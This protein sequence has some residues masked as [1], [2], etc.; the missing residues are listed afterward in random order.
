MT[1]MK[2]DQSYSPVLLVLVVILALMTANWLFGGIIPLLVAL[3]IWAITG[4]IAGYIVR[5]AGYNVMNNV[6]LGIAGGFMGSV[7][8][9]FLGLHFLYGIP[10]IGGIVVGVLGAVTLVYL[11]RIF[12]DSNFGR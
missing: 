7:L 6:L 4:S 1:K 3:V 2:N 10:F 9:R 11:M 5:G 12:V 8:V